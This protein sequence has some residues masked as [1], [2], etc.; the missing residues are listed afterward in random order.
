M[1]AY[2]RWFKKFISGKNPVE[3]E[4]PTPKPT[5][6]A[7]KPTMIKKTKKLLINLKKSKRR[8]DWIAI[9]CAATPEGKDFSASDI[10]S[11]HKRMGWRDIGYNYVIKLDGTVEEGRNV[12]IVPSHVR[13][14]NSNS[15]GVCYVGG[16]DKNMKAKDTRTKEQK[17]SLELLLKE[18]RKLYPNAK[19]QGHRDFPR[20]RKACPSFD[21]KTEYKHI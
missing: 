21:A 8:I 13:G 10:R 1:N 7:K 18:L 20:V 16:V 12:D 4:K 3:N 19:I 5:K 6:P 11:W 9:H 2:Q 14:Y 17:E 15:I